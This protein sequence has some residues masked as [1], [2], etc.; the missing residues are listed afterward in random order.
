MS[1][2]RV[3]RKD[4]SDPISL[5]EAR[6]IFGPHFE[7]SE[8]PVWVGLSTLAMGDINAVE[9][10]QSSHLGLCLQNLVARPEELLTLRGAIPH[11]LLQ[12]GIMVSDLVIL[13]QVL[14]QN[15]LQQCDGSTQ[16]DDIG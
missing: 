2:E 6:V 12:V 4:L 16:A 10:A 13:E 7:W 15:D 11:G 14:K 8:D 1:E 9:Y 5:A 3:Q